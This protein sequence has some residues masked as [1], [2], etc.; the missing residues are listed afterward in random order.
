MIKKAIVLLLA[1][2]LLTQV[3]AQEKEIN[4]L[5]DDW[6][7]AA[8]NADL[9]GYFGLIAE[10]GY[11]LGT[12]KTEIWT[13]SEFLEFSKPY[14]DK[15]KAWGFTAK[16]RS[17][18]FSKKKEVAWFEEVLVTWMGPCRGSGVLEKEKGEWKLKQYNLAMLVDNKDINAYLELIK[19]KEDE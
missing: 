2:G 15:G 19:E 12:D 8:A 10:D 6:H 9:E 3:S 11:F 16:S 1:C 5:L 13:K 7:K 14:F 17:V 18:F 4:Q